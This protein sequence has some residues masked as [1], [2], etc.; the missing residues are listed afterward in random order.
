MANRYGPQ[1]VTNGLVLCLD[2][3]NS[4]SYPGSGST[5]VDLSGNNNNG[6]LVNGPTFN[7][8]NGGSIAFDGVN[9]YINIGSAPGFFPGPSITASI[10]AW[11][12]PEVINATDIYLGIQNP[13]GHRLYIGNYF[14]LWDVGFGDF[15]WSGGFTGTRAVVSISWT[16]V[17]LN[18]ISGS[19]KLYIN[20]Q[21]TITK[22]TD[23]SVSLLGDFIIGAYT[24]NGS[25]DGSN[26]GPSRIASVKIYNRNLSE[27]EILQNYNAT[28]GRFGL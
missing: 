19:A 23:T 25:I 16:H 12:R 22:T 3:G 9:D 14:G 2:A 21:S 7:S 20:A 4:K 10:E 17:C 15:F 8:S 28:K 6:T 24:F 5:W 1:I 27:N 26:I 13:T 11:I 18:I